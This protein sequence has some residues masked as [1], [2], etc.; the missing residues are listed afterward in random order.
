MLSVDFGGR[1]A[2]CR[3]SG[4]CPCCPGTT[5]SDRCPGRLGPALA[6]HHLRR[7]PQPHP[8]LHRYCHCPSAPARHS[9]RRRWFRRQTHCD[10]HRRLHRHLHRRLHRHLHPHRQPPH[11]CPHHHRFPR[12]R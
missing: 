4:R 1:H 10:L 7:Q 11:H 9:H 6:T 5:H 8:C 12:P 2:R 3:V